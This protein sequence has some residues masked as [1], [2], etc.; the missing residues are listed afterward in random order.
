[1][2]AHA[3]K[4]DFLFRRN[5]RVHL[6]RPGR[7]FSRLLAA[8]LC[9]SSVVMLDTPCPEVVW[10]VL[11]TYIFWTGRLHLNRQGC[12]F[13]RLLAAELCASA[14]VMLDTPCSEVVWRVLNT[15]SIRQFSLHF[16]SRAR[17]CV[18]SHFN[19]TLQY[20]GADKSLA[21]PWRKQARS[22]S[23]SSWT[24]DPTRSREMPS[25]SAINLA[26][27]RRSSKI[28]SWIWSVISGVVGLRT[29]QHAAIWVS[30]YRGVF[31]CAKI[32]GF[33]ITRVRKQSGMK[34]S[35]EANFTSIQNVSLP[36]CSS[37]N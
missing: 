15:N 20:S 25:C 32:A 30:A 13:S 16:P 21:R 9:A 5:R 22:I 34:N 28:S 1:V 26:E 17:H 6:N 24:M 33:F 8:E 2:I 36:V 23:K 19:R 10:R 35:K 7:Q 3:Q 27:I 29:Y 37:V 14:L 12:Q 11:A 4:P 31:A 18:P